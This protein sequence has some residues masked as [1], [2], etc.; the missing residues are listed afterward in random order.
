MEGSLSVLLVVLV[1]AVI[2]GTNR[3]VLPDDTEPLGSCV[4]N[5]LE[6]LLLSAGNLPARVLDLRRVATEI[7]EKVA[8]GLPELEHL[9]QLRLKE[10]PE[11]M[12]V[13]VSLPR[14]PENAT[15]IYRAADNNI[16]VHRLSN[17]SSS[18]DTTWR[19]LLDADWDQSYKASDTSQLWTPPF[20]DCLTRKWLFGYS[21][22]LQRYV[23]FR[24]SARPGS[25]VNGVWVQMMSLFMHSDDII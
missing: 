4:P 12:A 17:L 19:N 10:H 13:A 15:V 23:Y 9:L 1:R 14:P 2:G 24:G 3:S 11:L 20:L 5:I 22:S 7:A 21:V 25:A 18:V 8:A 16:R 6:G